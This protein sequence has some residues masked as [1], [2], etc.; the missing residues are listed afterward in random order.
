MVKNRQSAAAILEVEFQAPIGSPAGVQVLTLG[1]LRSRNLAMLSRLQR[2]HF[3]QLITPTNR[4]MAFM[5]D[6][7]D[8]TA[9]PGSWLWVRPGRVGRWGDL[10]GVEGSLILFEDDFLDPDTA[11][12]ARINE[13]GAPTLYTPED[14][15]ESLTMARAHLEHESRALGKL[16]LSAHL[17][18]M[19]HLL[20]VLTI[21]LSHTGTTQSPA[22]QANETFRRFQ[23][24]V[25]RGFARTRRV[26]DYAAQ[27]GYSPRTLARAAFAA[28]GMGAKEFIDRRITLEAKRLLAHSDHTAAKIA[29]DLGF[30][31]ATNFSKYF[32]Q[33]TGQTPIAFRT[34]AR[35][36]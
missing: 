16:P 26:E 19:R 22:G 7:V 27:L 1:E 28:T 14:G 29:H 23:Y 34:N 33:R 17:S 13:P 5:V 4:R 36:R 6:F 10:T 20:A 35:Q 21:R 18:A 32:H 11:E 30:N 2:L 24:A 9:E 25:E 8:Y 31:D 12:T 3:H 15:G